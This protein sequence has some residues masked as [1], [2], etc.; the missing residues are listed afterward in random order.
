MK[1]LVHE[2]PAATHTIT[3]KM[4]GVTRAFLAFLKEAKTPAARYFSG[5]TF[6]VLSLLFALAK[7]RVIFF[8][9]AFLIRFLGLGEAREKENKSCQQH[10]TNIPSHGYHNNI[11]K[12]ALFQKGSYENI[13]NFKQLIVKNITAIQ[14]AGWSMENF[15]REENKGILVDVRA[16]AEF[17]NGHIRGAIN[18]PLF[19]DHERAEIGTL[20]KIKGKEEAVLRGI[21]LVSPKLATFIRSVKEQ[22]GS[23]EKVNVYCFRGGMRSSSFCWLMET[24]GLKVFKLEGG[25]KKYRNI[26]LSLFQQKHKL[27]LLGGSTGSGKTDVLKE[28]QKLAVQTVDLEAFAH[29]KGSAFGFIGQEKQPAQQ[30][31]ENNLYHAFS[32]LDPNKMLFLEDESYSIGTVSLPYDLWLQMKNAPI[33]KLQVPFEL[34]VKRLVA[35]YGQATFETLLRPLTAIKTRLGPQHYK[36]ALEHLQK[37]EMDKVAAITLHYYDKAY[38]H[39]H[40]K[41]GY[42][43]VFI[44]ETETDDPAVNAQLIHNFASSKEFKDKFATLYG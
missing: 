25:Y 44:V 3:G 11:K 6:L 15:L 4:I 24:A 22:N 36:T 18:I 5:R 12:I 16:P 2:T 14:T 26:A 20:Y 28:L 7:G 8:E 31:F 9:S 39:N 21:E 10:Y 27:V 19:D 30:Q 40:L 35:E 43:N 33:I 38:D 37:G 29:H 34:R 13:F 23:A 32:D 42:E 41:R 17:L 1:Y